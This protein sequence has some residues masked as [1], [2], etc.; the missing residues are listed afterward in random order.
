MNM[1]KQNFES[2]ENDGKNFIRMFL[3]I[4]IFKLKNKK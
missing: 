4:F 2:L 1:K 3:D